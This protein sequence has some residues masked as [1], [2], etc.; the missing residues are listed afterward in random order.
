MS[1]T[2][3]LNFLSVLTMLCGTSSRFVHV[4]VDPTGTDASAGAKLKLST[5]MSCAPPDVIAAS[6][7][8]SVI[9]I[10]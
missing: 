7:G 9:A 5:T 1:S 8:T 6:S 2:G 10:G 4:I 3:D